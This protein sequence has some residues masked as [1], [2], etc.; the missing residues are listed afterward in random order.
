[1]TRF[2][3][4]PR[5]PQYPVWSRDGRWVVF[6]SGQK[7]AAA[8]TSATRA[9]RDIYRKLSS[10]AGA[11]DLLLESPEDTL[12][13]SLSP[14]DR[15]LLDEEPGSGVWVLPTVGTRTPSVVMK[16]GVHSQFSPDGRWVA[17]ASG[18]SGQNEIY[19]RP[20]VPPGAAGPA[21]GAGAGQ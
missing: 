12:A 18:E 4:D 10:G 21:A 7:E 9:G 15:F 5:R 2:T 17:Y 6:S 11:E 13:R 1:M 14:D 8:R 16:S 20:F 19:V 3:F